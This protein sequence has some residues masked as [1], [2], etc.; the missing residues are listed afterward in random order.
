MIDIPSRG[1]FIFMYFFPN[2][3]SVQVNFFT[4]APFQL[5]FMSMDLV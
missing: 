5:G 2:I 3:L 1:P 4:Q